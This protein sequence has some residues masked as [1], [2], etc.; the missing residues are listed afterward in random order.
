MDRR[1]FLAGGLALASGAAAPSLTSRIC[2]F[3]DHLA[4]FNYEEVARMLKQLGVAG[5]DLTVRRG[6][7][8]PP[9]KVIQELPKAMAAFRDQGLTIPMITTN[10]LAANEPETRPILSAAAKLG[11]GYYITSWVTIST[12]ICLSGKR[13]WMRPIAS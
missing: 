6:G 7:L 13:L 9:D 2:L 11:I 4:G 10:I 3:T 12:K 8:V 5:P 1:Q